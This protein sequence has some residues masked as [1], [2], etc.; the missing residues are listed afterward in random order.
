MRRWKNSEDC[1][2]LEEY[3]NFGLS[4]LEYNIKNNHILDAEEIEESDEADWDQDADGYVAHV[5]S[6][7]AWGAPTSNEAEKRLLVDYIAR[8]YPTKLKL[9]RRYLGNEYSSVELDPEVIL[10]TTNN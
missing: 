3:D 2:T 5:C 4:D 8:N 9:I 6:I 10:E 1:S 7:A